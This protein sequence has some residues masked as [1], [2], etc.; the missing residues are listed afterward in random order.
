MS[1]L[2][3]NQVTNTVTSASA[4][5]SA[6][7]LGFWTAILT[8]VAATVALGI[9]VTTPPRSGTFCMVESARALHRSGRRWLFDDGRSFSVYRSHV[10]QA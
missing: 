8:A 7:R 6:C 9:G 2:K 1:Q 3:Q 4:K 10:R 5:Q